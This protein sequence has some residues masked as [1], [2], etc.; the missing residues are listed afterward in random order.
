LIYTGTSTTT[1]AT[2]SWTDANGVVL[3]T[4]AV[5][6][7]TTPGIYTLTVTAPN[8][9]TIQRMKTVTQSLTPPTANIS[10]GGDISCKSA[11]VTLTAS[12]SG[13]PVTYSWTG[14]SGFTSTLQNPAVA[15]A[16]DYT[17]KVR[18]PGG[19]LVEKVAHVSENKTVPQGVT[20]TITG[21][22]CHSGFLTLNGAST[23]S[24]VTYHWSSDT[25]FTSDEQNPV[26]TL[27]GH[28][29]LTVTN[30]TNGCVTTAVDEISTYCP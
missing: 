27:D 10:V 30:P 29:T 21:D 26:T 2:F 12:S 11:S 24:G 18:T 6:S 1:G 9:C 5:V 15:V 7:V 23:T 22:F 4:N 8:G 3:S 14:P 25:G 28:Y 13:S 16:G 19:C 20:F 17:L